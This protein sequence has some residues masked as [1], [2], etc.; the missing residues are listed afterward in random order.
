MNGK[1]SNKESPSMPLK[2]KGKRLIVAPCDWEATV[3]QRLYNHSYKKYHM[4]ST[5]F[6]MNKF[7]TILH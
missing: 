3:A 2:A 1:E 5:P 4:S 6:L 7:L